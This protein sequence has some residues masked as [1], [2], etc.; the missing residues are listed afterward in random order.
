M[1]AHTFKKAQLSVELLATNIP[2]KIL[3]DGKYRTLEKKVD[4]LSYL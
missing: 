3:I 4:S 2:D 1:L